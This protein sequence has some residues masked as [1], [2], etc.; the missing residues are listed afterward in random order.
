MDHRRI[1]VGV[2]VVVAAAALMSF[3]FA[4]AARAADV[5]G[6]KR[7]PNVI[8]ILTDDQGYADLGCYGSFKIKT[9]RIDRMAAEGMRFTD[10]YAP[11]RSA[12][13]RARGCSRAVTRSGSASCR[14]PTKSP[15][16]RRATSC[17]RSRNTG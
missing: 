9:P 14:S 10:F 5:G 11:R 1:A 4:F 3:A 17:T 6:V 12:R 2:V 7:P 13:R 15:A 8:V 16:A